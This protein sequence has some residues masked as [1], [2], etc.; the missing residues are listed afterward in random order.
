MTTNYI[1]TRLSDGATPRYGHG[2]AIMNNNMFVFGGI[3]SDGSTLG[4]F[5]QYDSVSD[6]WVSIPLAGTFIPTINADVSIVNLGSNL[7]LFGGTSLS[8]YL[9]QCTSLSW[10]KSSA[11]GRSNPRYDH[12]AVVSGSNMLI[13]GGTNGTSVFSDLRQFNGSIWS[14]R[15]SSTIARYAHTAVT[16]GSDMFVFGGIGTNGSDLNDLWV[17][18]YAANNWTQLSNGATPRHGHAAAAV[19]SD[20]YVFGGRDSNGN[21]LNDLWKYDTVAQVWTPLSTTG[22]IT[23]RNGQTAITVNGNILVFGGTTD[24]ASDGALNDLWELLIAQIAVSDISVS[25][26]IIANSTVTLGFN[27]SIVNGSNTATVTLSIGGSSYTSDF[28]MGSDSITFTAPS[29]ASDYPYTITAIDTAYPGNSDRVTGTLVVGAPAQSS[30]GSSIRNYGEFN[31][32]G[33]SLD[34]SLFLPPDLSV[35]ISDSSTTQEIFSDICAYANRQNSGSFGAG[36][37]INS[38]TDLFCSNAIAMSDPSIV[39]VTCANGVLTL[40]EAHGQFSLVITNVMSDTVTVTYSDALCGSRSN[41]VSD[42]SSTFVLRSS[43]A[44][45]AWFCVCQSDPLNVSTSIFNNVLLAFNAQGAIADIELINPVVSNQSISD[46]RQA[47]ILI[48][49]TKKIDNFLKQNFPSDYPD[50]ISGASLAWYN[51]PMTAN[52]LNIDL[53]NGIL[54]FSEFETNFINLY[55]DLTVCN[56]SDSDGA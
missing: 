47:C 54:V 6:V 3:G 27:L 38:Q 12:T 10:S 41:G 39:N 8:P 34:M 15:T 53:L 14:A 18:H 23:A 9:Y 28:A 44:Y 40:N 33:S 17:Y 52:K 37:I 26:S 5:W 56:A 43:D 1:W 48:N 11:L 45:F 32:I 50:N 19:G 35:T 55:S 4:D 49:T 13:F 2:T 31:L 36:L 20:M 29:I 46:L 51:G 24:N 16:I 25:D 21:E 7:Y 30:A 42:L 22:G